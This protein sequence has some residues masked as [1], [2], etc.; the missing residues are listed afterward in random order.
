MKH[1][2]LIPAAF[3]LLICC[4]GC[5]RSSS[6]GIAEFRLEVQQMAS[7]GDNCAVLLLIHTDTPGSISIDGASMHN[8]T[9]LSGTDGS[10]E[11]RVVL[12]ATRIAPAGESN[13]YIQT[14]SRAQTPEGGYAGGPVVHTLPATTKLE[15]VFVVTAQSGGY[16][17]NKPIEI[18]QEMGGPITLTVGKPTK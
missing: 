15:D 9:T 5:N 11:G 1:H 13:A 8:S 16:S 14:L 10:Y 18:A 17:L 2:Y 4:G 12:L 6:P 7:G 3:G